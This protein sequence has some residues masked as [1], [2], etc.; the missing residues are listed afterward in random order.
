MWLL[1]APFFVGVLIMCLSLLPLLNG[2][3]EGIQASMTLLAAGAAIS[4]LGVL[5]TRPIDKHKDR[6]LSRLES[7]GILQYTSDGYVLNGVA[8]PKGRAAK[9]ESVS[10]RR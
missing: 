1:F 10:E 2:V 6:I 7:E 4:L 9:S 8:Y 5:F 3:R